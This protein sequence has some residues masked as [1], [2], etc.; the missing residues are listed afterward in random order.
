MKITN[1]TIL[2]YN[3]ADTDPYV[4]GIAS[5]LAS[6]GY[7]ERPTVREMLTFVSRTIIRRTET[8]QR[9]SV[10]HEG[11]RPSAPPPGQSTSRAALE[12]THTSWRAWCRNGH[13]G[14]VRQ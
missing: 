11:A 4:L 1:I 5:D 14:V 9:Q 13:E 8:G 12:R 3:G 7:F 6:F 2:K 10:Q